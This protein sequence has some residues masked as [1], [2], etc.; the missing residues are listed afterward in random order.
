MNIQERQN[1]I[2]KS[3]NSFKK[4][5]YHKSEI[6]PELLSYQQEVVNI[7]FSDT[8]KEKN[9]L[10]FWDAIEHYK[11]LNAEHKNIANSELEKFIIDCKKAN[12][13]I[14]AEI[15]GNRGE[16]IVLRNLETLKI[17]NTISKNIE[18]QNET[19]RS[20]ID[21]VVFTQKGAFII[22]VK[23]TKKNIFI[24]RDGL[25]FRVTDERQQFDSNIAEKMQI[26]EALLR[27][28]LD[29]LGYSGLQIF[30]IV[31]FTNTKAEI[32]NKCK[33][34]QTCFSN[35]LATI[36]ENWNAPIYLRTNDLYIMSEALNKLSSSAT[37]PMEL[38][39]EAAKKNFALL[40]AKL[41]LAESSK[42]QMQTNWFKNLASILL[43]RNRRYSTANAATAV[44]I[45][46]TSI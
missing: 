14:K 19:T 39:T 15:S 10:R 34:L 9:T 40:A 7:A 12:N 16:E 46:T 29:K 44:G 30:K 1:Q 4:D 18:L 22:E 35:Q 6:L 20:E 11:K 8:T 3:I 45:I 13:K 42:A 31:V 37:F 5:L 32:Q 2:Y 43:I 38:D 25:F 33:Q 21:T 36:I 24:D 17:K 27:N 28:E 41:E 23:N 26:K